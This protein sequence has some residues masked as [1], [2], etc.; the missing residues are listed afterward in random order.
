[1]NSEIEER[2]HEV[3]PKLRDK[4]SRTSGTI[5]EVYVSL[6]PPRNMT[7]AA[8]DTLNYVR[9]LVRRGDTSVRFFYDLRA[10]QWRQSQGPKPIEKCPRYFPVSRSPHIWVIREETE[11]CSVCGR[12]MAPEERVCDY[13]DVKS[14]VNVRVVDWH[15]G[16]TFSVTA[17]GD[18]EYDSDIE[19]RTFTYNYVYE[20][21][22]YPGH[23]VW[24][25]T[26][27]ED[28]EE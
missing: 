14:G 17:T 20:G 1:M 6:G 9:A 24:N 11:K 13:C 23:A 2:V 5:V 16:E 19:C 3:L 21:V 12:A 28:R 27:W 7:G 10:R 4:L 18:A 8:P 26:E 22:S 15:T 25:G